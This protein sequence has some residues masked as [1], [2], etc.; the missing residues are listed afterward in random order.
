MDDGFLSRFAAQL[1]IQLPDDSKKEKFLMKSVQT[2]NLFIETTDVKKFVRIHSDLYSLRE[3]ETVVN[4]AILDGPLSR[5]ENATHFIYN[6]ISDSYVLCECRS[7]KCSGVLQSHLTI[8]PEKI[9]MPELRFVDLEKAAGK[10]TIANSDQIISDNLKFSEGI[11]KLN[12]NE[13]V[14]TGAENEAKLKNRS[15]GIC[16][17]FILIAIVSLIT[18]IIIF[19]EYILNI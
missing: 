15:N 3:C 17:C 14:I 2:K 4:Q 19:V 6:E 1:Y 18:V 12:N 13:N 10:V 5:I 9:V 16:A 8:R 11:C 7:D